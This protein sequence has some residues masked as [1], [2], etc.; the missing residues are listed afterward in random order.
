[1]K[2]VKF[3]KLDRSPLIGGGLVTLDLS[4]RWL[5]C[6]TLASS[7]SREKPR[8]Q[9]TNAFISLYMIARTRTHTVHIEDVFLE[10]HKRVKPDL[11]ILLH[12][13]SVFSSCPKFITAPR[14][15]GNF[16]WITQFVL[17]KRYG[18]NG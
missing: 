17:F 6:H 18:N 16:Y 8:W 7:A 11:L 1:L 9:R 5:C 4:M 2:S 13:P 10:H 12:S 15:R 3:P 14:Y